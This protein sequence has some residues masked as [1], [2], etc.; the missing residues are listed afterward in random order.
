VDYSRL[1]PDGPRSPFSEGKRD[2][3][4]QS[5]SAVLRD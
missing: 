4:R 2:R 1:G 3:D 5:V